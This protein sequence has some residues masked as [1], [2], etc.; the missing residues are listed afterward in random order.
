MARWMRELLW[1][2]IGLGYE[3]LSR[4]DR[5][6][7]QHKGRWSFAGNTPGRLCANQAHYL[8]SLHSGATN[9]FHSF[10]HSIASEK[11]FRKNSLPALQNSSMPTQYSISP[12][13]TFG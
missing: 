1:D 5:R 3:R 10:F 11:W 2:M 13:L 7:Y 8:S 12:S 9:F 4:S 6:F